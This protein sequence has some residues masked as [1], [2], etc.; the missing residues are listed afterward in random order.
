MAAFHSNFI[1]LK[2]SLKFFLKVK[3]LKLIFREIKKLLL[4]LHLS[5]NS[6]EL[7]TKIKSMFRNLAQNVWSSQNS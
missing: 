7:A 5:G 4:L 1:I 2:C 3:K 6:V